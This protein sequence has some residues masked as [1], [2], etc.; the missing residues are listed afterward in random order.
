MT[1]VGF[2]YSVVLSFFFFLLLLP[3]TKSEDLRTHRKNKQNKNLQND[4]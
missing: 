3:N 4:L 2:P 1:D